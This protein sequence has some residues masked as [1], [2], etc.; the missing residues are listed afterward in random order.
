MLTR[1]LVLWLL[2]E[3]SHHGYRI[4]KILEEETLRF[5]FPLE[6]G[7]IYAVLRSL[8]RG[9]FVQ[10]VAVE[11]EGQRPERTTYAITDAGRR[12]LEELLRRAWRELRSPAE[13]IQLA[14]AARPELEEEE[15]HALLGERAEALRIRLGLLD[16]L[17]RSA[18]A[19]EMV[20]R[21]R[22]LTKAELKWAEAL[23]VES[24]PTKEREETE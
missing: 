24:A 19:P 7:S 17:A 13:P 3:T 16:E 9:G 22:A 5:W 2:S 8:V 10:A 20:D 21:Q 12:H 14:L 4:K 23:L 6:Y 18:P 1:M 15:V 11:R